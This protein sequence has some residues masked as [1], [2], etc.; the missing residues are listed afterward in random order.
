MNAITL[1]VPMLAW[2]KFFLLFFIIV[3]LFMLLSTNVANPYFLILL[4]FAGSLIVTVAAVLIFNISQRKVVIEE[5]EII[6]KGLSEK[7]IAYKDIEK[8][9]VGSG[10]ISLYD[11]QNSVNITTMY[12][13][14][15][16]AREYILD[17]IDFTS[18]IEIKG[19]N[20][21][22]KKHLNY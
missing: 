21:Y 6:K 5:N 10:G 16:A 7:S 1:K 17:K 20:R 19:L 13:N 3:S 15:D 11:G 14:F 4:T 2:I 9:K 12:S 8:I 22:K 18:E